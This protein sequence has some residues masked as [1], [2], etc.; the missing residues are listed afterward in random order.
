MQV[1]YTPDIPPGFR[2]GRL[3][4]TDYSRFS[5]ASFITRKENTLAS[6]GFGTFT[7]EQPVCLS[8]WIAVVP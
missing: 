7:L 8:R 2:N 4:L 3:D 1:I 6:K 5:H